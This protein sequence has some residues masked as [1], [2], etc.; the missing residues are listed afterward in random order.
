MGGYFKAINEFLKYK[1]LG[2]LKERPII[3]L[4][5]IIYFLLNEY[6]IIIN[7]VII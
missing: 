2:Y 7:K 1:F 4:N 6:S 5:K 3:Y